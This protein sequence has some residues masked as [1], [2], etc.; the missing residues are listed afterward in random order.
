MTQILRPRFGQP[1]FSCGVNVPEPRLRELRERVEAQG[2]AF[3]K[4]DIACVDCGRTAD[5][6]AIGVEPRKR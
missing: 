6:R 5:M 3:R 1:C 2:R 4:D